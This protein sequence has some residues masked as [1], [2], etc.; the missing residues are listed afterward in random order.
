[1]AESVTEKV[2][3]TK[4]TVKRLQKIYRSI[5]AASASSIF[6]LV[7]TFVLMNAQ[8]ILGNWLNVSKVPKLTMIEII[9]LGCL[10]FLILVIGLTLFVLLTITVE[11]YAHPFEFFVKVGGAVWESFK[12][13][14]E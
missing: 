6:G 13:L 5:N 14:F 10:D 8:L 7:I 4:E 9:L 11:A 12:G 2:K 3:N 1:M